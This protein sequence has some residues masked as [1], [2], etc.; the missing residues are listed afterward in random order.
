MM[1]LPTIILPL[2]PFRDYAIPF[3]VHHA[4]GDRGRMGRQVCSAP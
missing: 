3:A 4:I 2:W 1:D